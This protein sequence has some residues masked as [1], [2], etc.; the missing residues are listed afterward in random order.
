MEEYFGIKELYDVSLKC[1]FPMEIKG[2]TY[3]TNE[4]IIKFDRI[5]LAPLSEAKTRTYASGGYGNPQLITWEK[6]NEIVFTISEGVISKMGLAIL[7]NSQLIE[8]E[9]NEETPV[10]FS[11]ELESDD[12]GKIKLKY[13]PD[14]NKGL[15]IYDV[16]TNEKITSYQI[17]NNIIDTEIPYKNLYIDY[18]FLYKEKA[19]TLVIGKRLINGYLKLE[20]KIKLKDD[21]DGKI[22]T[23]IIEFP[24][25]KLMSD[26]SLRLGYETSPYVY[27]FQIVGLPVED[28]ENPY[29]CKI[30]M[31]NNEID[32]DL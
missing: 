5:Q 11:E 7:S 8:S 4:S 9:K 26:L 22:K 24:R 10:S 32:S 18:T 21:F 28:K 19:E 14:I 20:G 27:R 6:T 15:F 23:G 1:N 17:E 30:I 31:L 3:E 2:R 12:N 25:V 16:E 13:T 29:V